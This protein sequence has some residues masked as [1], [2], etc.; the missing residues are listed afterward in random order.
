VTFRAGVRV[1]ARAQESKLTERGAGLVALQL[2]NHMVAAAARPLKLLQ[3]CEAGWRGCGGGPRHRG[4]AHLAGAAALGEACS[5][6][7]SEQL[8]HAL[9]QKIDGVDV[10]MAAGTLGRAGCPPSGRGVVVHWRLHE[11]QVSNFADFVPGR[12]CLLPAELLA[13]GRCTVI[14]KPHAAKLPLPGS[15]PHPLGFC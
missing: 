14:F 1:Q 2:S 11:L 7:P 8:A 9:E 3:A 4:A 12:D 5:P 6:A 15:S 13:A 10:E